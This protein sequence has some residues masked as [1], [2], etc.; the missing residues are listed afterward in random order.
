MDENGNSGIIHSIDGRCVRDQDIIFA[1][2]LDN[3]F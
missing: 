1:I 3:G 2:D